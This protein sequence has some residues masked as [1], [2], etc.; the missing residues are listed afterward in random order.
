MFTSRCFG[1]NSG[2]WL[3]DLL[4]YSLQLLLVLLDC[5]IVYCDGVRCVL[6]GWCVDFCVYFDLFADDFALGL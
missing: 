6:L 2:F 1:L 3:V 5:G 4:G